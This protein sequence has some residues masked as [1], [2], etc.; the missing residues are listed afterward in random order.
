MSRCNP[1]PP[2]IAART[3]D[4]IAADLAANRAGYVPEW[5]AAPPDAGLALQRVL[6]RQIEVQ[7]DGLDAM[8]QRLQ[9]AF[10]E[11][12]GANVLPA[13]SAR[14]PLVF[15]LLATASG[16]ATVPAGTRVAAVLPPPAPSLDGSVPT[17][18][19]QAPEYF[20]EQE[21]TAMRGA[22][23]TLHSVD[24][25]ADTFNDHSP[26]NPGGFAVFDAR[27]PMPHRLYLG[28]AE[29]FNFTGSA[30][31][32]L[33]F[34]FASSSSTGAPQVQRALLLDWEYLSA[35]GWQPLVQVDDGTQRFTRDGKITLAKFHGPD[36]Q[37]GEVGGH[38]SCWIRATVSARTPQARVA[39][40]AAG[41]LVRYVSAGGAPPIL[42]GDVVDIGGTLLT[43]LGADAGAL[44]LASLPASVAPK[45]PIQTPDGAALGK[46]VGSTPHFRIAVDDSR[47]VLPGDRVT[48]DGQHLAQVVQTDGASVYLD[49]EL[50]DVQ[51]GLTLALA[52]ALPPLRPDGADEAGALPQV[53]TIRARVGFGERDLT[54]DS[55]YRDGF[56]LDTSA[57]FHPFGKQPLRFSTCYLACKKAFSRRG[58][59]IELSI[60]LL[61]AGRADTQPQVQAEYF[62]GGRWAALGANDDYIDETQHLT[63]GPGPDGLPVTPAQRIAF[64]APLDWTETEVNAEKQLWLRLRLAAGDYGSPATATFTPDPAAPSDPTKFKVVSTP[65]TVQ[66]P[67]VTRVG[68]SYL[69]FTN[70]QPLEACVAENDFAFSEHTEDARWPRRLFSPFVPVSDR[71]PA[72]HFGF[73][74]PPPAALVSLLVQVDEP[75][76]EGA[77]Q[78]LVW[79]YWGER[80][81]T[82]LSVRDTTA[83]LAQTGLLQFIGAPDALPREGLGGRLYRMRARLKSGLAAGQQVVQCGGAWLNA[84]WA[85]QGQRVDRDTLGISSGNPDQTYVLPPVR[86]AKD[87]PAAAPNAGALNA[88]DFERA[89]DTP[90]SGVPVL[91]GEEVWVREWTG[92][93]DDW[94]TAVA[95]VAD[96]DLRLETDPQQP[97]VAVAAWVRWWAQPHFYRSGPADRHCVIER[98]RGVFRFPG[99]G[100]FI[101]PAGCLITASYVTGGGV[102]GNVAAGSIKE[103]RSG[104]GYVQSVSNPLSASGGAAAELLRAARDRSAQAPRNRGRAVSAE[105]YEWLALEATSELARARALP[106]AG[107]AGNG[108]RGFVGLV[109]VPHSPDAMPQPSAQLLDTV[110][111]ALARRMP[112]GVA[113]GLVLLAP[114]YVPVVVQAEVLPLRAEEAGQIEAVLR[115]RLAAFLHPLSGGR[116]GQ[117]WPFGSGVYLSDIAALIEGTPGVDAV[118]SLQLLVDLAVQ[119]DSV[120]V[121][122]DQLI[123]AG[124]PQLKLVVPSQPYAL[125]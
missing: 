48:L 38:A 68:I 5:T 97:T 10:L 43:A 20:T 46:V 59:T 36:S 88:A 13:Q 82:E 117:G 77:P 110:R 26:M 32:V 51:P 14:A 1:R 115:N 66:P 25:Q 96:A 30:Q 34:D 93:G 113:G 62:N 40:E 35:D 101:P 44:I 121:Q 100:G 42:A 118:R 55:A 21:I 17:P 86:A 53:D 123:A 104:V 52:D 24:P 33:S 95:G 106:L 29:Y 27:D 80:G 89:L 57:D 70:P 81:W 71:A 87:S 72:L 83:G 65:D 6:A 3:A 116:D 90:L 37:D 122:P 15:K 64:R 58:A 92:R 74:N 78:P 84:V 94:Q 9:L 119:G 19:A 111:R 67:I 49:R 112:A 103:L 39:S 105:D 75:A 7:D 22:L 4:A 107:P 45:A 47:D 2:V 69:V 79:D 125:A 124:S 76:A 16:D 54:I 60:A 11:S 120:V 50:D 61:Q 108:S 98:A 23:V 41:Y 31:I 85:S 8:P 109:L 99:I 91:A 12:L 56:K 73:D 102:A 114:S 28:H 63:N 18:R